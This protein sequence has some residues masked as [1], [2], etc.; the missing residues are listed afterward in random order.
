[1]SSPENRNT[2][3]APPAFASSG[4]GD[5]HFSDPAPER[6]ARLGILGHHGENLDPLGVGQ[7]AFGRREICRGL[8]DG[9]WQAAHDTSIDAIDAVVNGVC[10]HLHGLRF[11]GAGFRPRSARGKAA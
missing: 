8:H 6:H 2:T 5:P 11:Q 7:N 1:M 10:L 3:R 4:A 9:L